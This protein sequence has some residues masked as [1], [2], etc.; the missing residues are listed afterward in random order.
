M[1]Y[2]GGAQ[3]SLH[4]PAPV[5]HQKLRF[6][7]CLHLQ[8][9]SPPCRPLLWASAGVSSVFFSSNTSPIGDTEATWRPTRPL[10]DSQNFWGAPRVVHHFQNFMLSNRN[11]Y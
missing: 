6:N 11:I 7:F 5:L 2:A 3:P 1:R 8:S 9:I 4:P 10:C